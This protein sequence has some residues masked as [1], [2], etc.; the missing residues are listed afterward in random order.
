MGMN[1]I[2]HCIS[3]CDHCTCFVM[4]QGCHDRFVMSRTKNGDKVVENIKTKTKVFNLKNNI[5]KWRKFATK[6]TLIKPLICSQY[7]INLVPIINV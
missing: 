5:V 6:T 7:I 1:G 2:F 3:H 4:E